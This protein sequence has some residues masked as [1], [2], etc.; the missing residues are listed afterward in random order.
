MSVIVVLR[1]DCADGR[2]AYMSFGG[3]LMALRGSY[4]HLSS[5]TIGENVYL[6]IRK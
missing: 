5:I 3:L 2:T 1:S 4:R 6:L